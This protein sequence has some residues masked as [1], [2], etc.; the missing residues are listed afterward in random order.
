MILETTLF[1]KTIIILSAQ[2]GL[3]V[4]SCFYCLKSARKA[5]ENNTTFLG[6][7]FRGAVN[8]KNE[9]DLIPYIKV[10]KIFPAKMN[11]INEKLHPKKTRVIW[12]NNR[13]EL[14]GYLKEGYQHE[15]DS[16]GTF[17]LF[18]VFFVWFLSL[19]ACTFFAT[20]G[21]SIFAGL[22]LFTISSLDFWPFASSL[23]CLKWMR[24]MALGR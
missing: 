16:T 13:Q 4:A 7:S 24:M 23:S 21:L 10:P 6:S 2:L 19:G 17:S 8:M 15:G 11:L 9:L 12:A 14:I 22:S 20:S 18:G 1:L 5:Y 3:S